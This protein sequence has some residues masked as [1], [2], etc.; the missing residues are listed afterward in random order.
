MHC[1]DGGLAIIRVGFGVVLSRAAIVALVDM[2]SPSCHI[3]HYCIIRFTV[4]QYCLVMV[5][6]TFYTCIVAT[7][8]IIVVMVVLSLYVLVLDWF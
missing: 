8:S 7:L 1:C 2:V 5:G 4:Q 3:D 6:S